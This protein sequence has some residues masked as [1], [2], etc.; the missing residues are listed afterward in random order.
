MESTCARRGS[1][2]RATSTSGARSAWPG[3]RPVGFRDIRVRF[4]VDTDADDDTP[5]KLVELTERYCVVLQT[6]RSTTP[7]ETNVVRSGDR[8]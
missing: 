2:P 8:S 1:P 5:A 4:D 7:A 6:V 3:T